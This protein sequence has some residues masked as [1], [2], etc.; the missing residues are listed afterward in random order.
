MTRYACKTDEELLELLKKSDEGAF[1]EL[2]D[3]YWERIAVYVS[4]VIKGQDDAQDIVQEIFISIWRRR[5][6][7]SLKSTLLA[8]LLRSARNL[9][10]RYIE[11]NINQEDLIKSLSE[12]VQ[13]MDLSAISVLEL[14]ELESKVDEAIGKLPEKMRQVYLLSRH[15]NLSY[16]EIASQLGIA[17]TT[18]KKQVSNALKHIRLEIEGLSATSL[19]LI[20]FL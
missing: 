18:V 7:I 13:S 5:G 9:S 16:R 15:E 19:V 11:R 2:F 8:Y 4:K 1:T 3:R 17:E 14:Q 6:D 20:F 10:I 12:Q